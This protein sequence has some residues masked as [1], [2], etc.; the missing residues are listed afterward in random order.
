M[1]FEDFYT[2]IKNKAA[3]MSQLTI[4][5]CTAPA[6]VSVAF[7]L[8]FKPIYPPRLQP[9]QTG[10]QLFPYGTGLMS[11]VGAAPMISECANFDGS[12]MYY[13]VP[14]DCNCTKSEN[15]AVQVGLTQSKVSTTCISNPGATFGTTCTVNYNT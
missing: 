11:G 5:Q 15:A 14:Y 2:L 7:P 8:N 9:T 6:P 13:R 10:V 12:G 1:H 3:S 4:P